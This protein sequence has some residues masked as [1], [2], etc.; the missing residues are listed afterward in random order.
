MRVRY[1]AVR[2]RA[3]GCGRPRPGLFPDPESVIRLVVALLVEMEHEMMRIRR[4][5]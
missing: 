1:G 3:M 4:C 5:S 2:L